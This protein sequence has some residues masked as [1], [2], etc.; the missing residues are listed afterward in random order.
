MEKDWYVKEENIKNTHFF[1]EIDKDST[2]LRVISLEK[3]KCK[4]LDYPQSEEEGKKFIE[5]IGLPGNWMQIDYTLD[6]GTAYSIMSGGK[7]DKSTK[8]IKPKQPY[9]SWTYN[10]EKNRWYAPISHPDDNNIYLWDEESQT[11]Y[12]DY[13]VE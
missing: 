5:Q 9:P 1:A 12:D 10:E 4:N 8:I 3:S 7:V 2:V 6:A 11:W 13:E